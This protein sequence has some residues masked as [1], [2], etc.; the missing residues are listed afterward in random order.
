M[1]KC[2]FPARVSLPEPYQLS[3]A[4]AL[5][6]QGLTAEQGLSEEEAARRLEQFEVRGQ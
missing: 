1:P 6:A 2:G 3:I 4:D 5:T